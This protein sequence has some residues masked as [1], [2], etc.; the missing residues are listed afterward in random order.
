[1]KQL[2]ITAL[3][4]ILIVVGILFNSNAFSQ[5]SNA[6]RTFSGTVV[7]QQFELVPNVSI[8]VQTADGNLTTVTDSEGYFSLK[9]PSESLSVRFFGKSLNQV[10]RIFA[11]SDTLVGLQIKISYNTSAVNESVTIE[12]DSVAPSVA[13]AAI[14]AAES[15]RRPSLK[16]LRRRRK[17]VR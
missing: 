13:A 11:V 3:L 14:R 6:N 7:N 12:A 10:T 17:M 8:E 9:V 4:K 1:M 15:A 2:R 5:T 16:N